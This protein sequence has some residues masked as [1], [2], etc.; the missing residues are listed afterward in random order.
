MAKT[1]WNIPSPHNAKGPK[2]S[3]TFVLMCSNPAGTL[4]LRLGI[5]STLV[6]PE[7]THSGNGAVKPKTIINKTIYNVRGVY[8]ILKVNIVPVFVVLSPGYSPCVWLFDSK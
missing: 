8:K 4:I 7:K 5:C 3:S 2:E 6:E 1:V